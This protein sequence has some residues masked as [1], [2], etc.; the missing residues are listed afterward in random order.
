MIC[1]RETTEGELPD[2]LA[3][4]LARLPATGGAYLLLVDL[5]APLAVDLPGR[6]PARLAPGRYAYC[7]SAYG[8]G[9]LRARIAR[10]LRPAKRAHWHIDRLT[11]A[12]RVVAVY[13]LPGGRECALFASLLATPGARVPLRGFGSSDCRTCPAH[14]AAVP[15]AFD[16]RR[17]VLSSA[18]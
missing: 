11:G 10:H 3:G 18:S 12:G 7:G 15:P 6:P 14:L 4:G 16:A 8:P 1:L 17:M 2:S 5:P 13:G 9:G